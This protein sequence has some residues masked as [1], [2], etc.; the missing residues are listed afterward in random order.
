MLTSKRANSASF[1]SLQR[2]SFTFK[3]TSHF[4][5]S[6]DKTANEMQFSLGRVIRRKLNVNAML[7]MSTSKQAN[8]ASFRLS[9]GG[10]VSTILKF[11]SFE[12]KFII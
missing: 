3:E 12:K 4:V 10:V 1:C 8:S 2:L 11:G 5:A 6:R 9:R 7:L